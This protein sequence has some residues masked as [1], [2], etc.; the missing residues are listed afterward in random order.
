MI[1]DDPFN[2][3]DIISVF[4]ECFLSIVDGNFID[5][6]DNLYIS[7]LFVKVHVIC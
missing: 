1:P 2:S 7:S 3:T 4:S 5:V 6:V